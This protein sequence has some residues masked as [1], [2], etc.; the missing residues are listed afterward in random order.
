M[1]EAIRKRRSV[2]D[3]LDRAV[4][5]DKLKEILKA[6]MFSPTARNLRPWEFVVVTDREQKTELSGATPYASFAANAPVVL[7]ICYDA[8]KGRRFKEDCSLAAE[9]I[10]LESVNQGLGTCFIQIAE[11]TEAE[12]GEPEGFVK[13]LLG[14][15][16]KYRVQCL[17]PVG[18]PARLPAP[19]RDEEFE[20]D[21]IHYGGFGIGYRREG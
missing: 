20:E 9:N 21:K 13:K 18:Y 11:G 10:Y 1:L 17:M 4:E 15:P 14:I 19:H 8:D 16:E 7:V 5:A 2:R 3:F 12:K 6:A